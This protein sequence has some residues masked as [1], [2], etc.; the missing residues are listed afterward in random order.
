ML[1]MKLAIF[2]FLIIIGTVFAGGLDKYNLDAK[3]SY[4]YIARTAD[5]KEGIYRV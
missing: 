1:V 3:D 5:G 4:L 2:V